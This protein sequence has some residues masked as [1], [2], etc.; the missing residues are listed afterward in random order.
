MFLELIL[1]ELRGPCWLQIPLPQTNLQYISPGQ[2]FPYPQTRPDP[3]LSLPF[4]FCSIIQLFL[5][6][7]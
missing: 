5:E 7:D 1:S 6:G 3:F 2:A 4:S